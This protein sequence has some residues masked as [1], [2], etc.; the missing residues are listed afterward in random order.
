MEQVKLFKALDTY[1]LL[2]S[3][4]QFVKGHLGANLQFMIYNLQYKHVY[5]KNISTKQNKEE[6]NTWF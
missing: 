1:V 5:K 4:P 2:I 3:Y 6:K